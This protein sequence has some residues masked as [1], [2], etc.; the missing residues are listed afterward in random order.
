MRHKPAKFNGKATPDDPGAWIRDCEKKFCVL[1]CS[2]EQKLAFAT[3]LLVSDV[4]YWWV[5]MQQQMQTR[6]EEVSWENFKRRFLEKY[7]LDSAKHER[8]AKF[9]TLQQGN[10]TVQAYVNKFEYLAR[11]YT[12]YHSGMALSEV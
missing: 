2:N 9:L 3:F 8:E 4:E 6:E 1:A 10:M 5:G 11:F 12:K 7:F